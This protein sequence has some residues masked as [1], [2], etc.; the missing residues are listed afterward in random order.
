MGHIWSCTAN[1]AILC[2]KYTSYH[3]MIFRISL[4]STTLKSSS[5]CRDL[6]NYDLKSHFLLPVLKY[7][8]LHWLHISLLTATL[9]CVPEYL[10][11]LGHVQQIPGKPLQILSWQEQQW[12]ACIASF[13]TPMFN[14]EL[15]SDILVNCRLI[16][17]EQSY[18]NT[19]LY[20]SLIILQ[21]FH[22]ILGKHVRVSLCS[23]YEIIYTIHQG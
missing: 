11:F 19:K 21:W 14:M 3:C 12:S 20:I 18:H 16:N 4:L 8:G 5:V 1:D 10:H 22:V 15:N 13:F 6:L 17:T 23:L 2:N 9:L 7:K